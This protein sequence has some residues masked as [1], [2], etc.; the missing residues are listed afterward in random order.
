MIHRELGLAWDKADRKDE[1]RS[2]IVE[3]QA[4]GGKALQV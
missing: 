3:K 4:R 1:F 2:G